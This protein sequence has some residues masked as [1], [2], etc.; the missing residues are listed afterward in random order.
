LRDSLKPHALPDA[1]AGGVEDVAEVERLF[2]DGDDGAVAVGGVEDKDEPILLAGEML[3]SC[4]GA[5]T[6]H[7]QRQSL[8]HRWHRR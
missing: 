6:A 4:C 3:S 8:Q 7:C 1:A 2:A 5:L